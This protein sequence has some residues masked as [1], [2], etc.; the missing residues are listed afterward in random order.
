M[1]TQYQDATDKPARVRIAHEIE[2]MIYDI[3]MF[4]PMY[5]VPYTREAY[6]RWLRLPAWHGTR[7]TDALFNPMAEGMGADGLFWI[8]EARK[9]E[10]LAARASGMAFPPVTIIDETWH[11]K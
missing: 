6:W 4:I 3:G 5:K 11:V 1:I 9:T 2:R 8:D 7:T 10:T